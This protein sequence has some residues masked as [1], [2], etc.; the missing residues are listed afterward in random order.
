MLPNHAP[1]L[2][3]VV[4]GLVAGGV[5]AAMLLLNHFLGPRRHNRTKGA[6][7]ECGSEPFG[8]PRR[9]FSVKYYLVAIFFIVFD[10][11]AVFLYPWAVLYKDFMRDAAMAWVAM[12]EMFLFL[13]IL[14]VG[15]LYVW[16]RGALEWD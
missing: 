15:L 4:V 5:A 13:G 14:A 3:V 9:R 11:E 8:D 6:P 7:F 12:I 2:P 10:I 16:R 1:Y